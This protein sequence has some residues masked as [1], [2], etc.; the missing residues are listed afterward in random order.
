MPENEKNITDSILNSVKKMLGLE[1]D[2]TEF[3]PDVIINI[4]SAFF[5][6]SQLGV[7]PECG[8]NIED[9][10]STYHDY[11]GDQPQLIHPVKMYLY[12]KTRLGFD[13]SSTSAS[14]KDQ[15]KDEIR[16][17]EWRMMAQVE[18]SKK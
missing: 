8:F 13:I 5:T 7:G 1:P 3:D 11:L 17:L 10:S 14:V 2:N 6:L 18:F 16:E 15:I 12:D 4:N 9:D